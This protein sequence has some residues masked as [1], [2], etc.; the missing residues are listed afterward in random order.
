MDAVLERP[1]GASRVFVLLHGFNQSG[2]RIFEKLRPCLPAT[3]AVFAPNALFPMLDRGAG[4]GLRV[5]FSWYFYDGRVDE[6]FIEPESAVEFVLSGLEA[7][8]LN[9]LPVTWIGFSQGG[10]LAPFCAARHL[11]TERV[12]GINC[13][14]LIDEVLDQ[15]QGRLP[16]RIDA[17]HGA[18]DETVR[19][20][21]GRQS[22]ERFRAHVKAGE[23]YSIPDSSH[24][25][26]GAILAKLLELLA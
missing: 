2:L 18:L 22:F 20:E 7:Y 10:Y 1:E 13:E 12:I 4:D 3:A 25:I 5:G 24:R 9:D 19:E 21:S 26:D 23:F 16:F 11:R 17:I 8:G 14:Y 6:Y 15:P